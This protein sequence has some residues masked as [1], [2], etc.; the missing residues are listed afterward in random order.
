MVEVGEH[1]PSVTESIFFII[2]GYPLHVLYCLFNVH[3]YVGNTN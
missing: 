3:G 1:N 2:C